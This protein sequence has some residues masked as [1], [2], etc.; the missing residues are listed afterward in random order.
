MNMTLREELLATEKAA[1]ALYQEKK[2]IKPDTNRLGYFQNLRT[3]ADL[4]DY[5]NKTMT[6]PSSRQREAF[7]IENGFRSCQQILEIH[8]DEISKA[9]KTTIRDIRIGD[10]LTTYEICSLSGSYDLMHGM[11]LNNDDPD[12]PFA[13]LRSEIGGMYADRV[14]S[15]PRYYNYSLEKESDAHY[16]KAQ[17]S[18]PVN[19]ALYSDFLR[20]DI[21]TQVK[22]LPAHLFVRHRQES[23]YLYQGVYFVNSLIDK[24]RTFELISSRFVAG[25]S[26]APKSDDR[27]LLRKFKD[28]RRSFFANFYAK[29]DGAIIGQRRLIETKDLNPKMFRSSP[30]PVTT[31]NYDDLTELLHDYLAD[32]ILF[33]RIGDI[34]EKFAFDF[35]VGRVKA[36]APQQVHNIK[37]VKDSNG[38]DLSSYE[39][40]GKTIR[41][42]QIEVKSTINKDPYNPFF[43]SSNE[44][45]TM[46]D[47]PQTYWLYRVF[48]INAVDPKLF[49]LRGGVKENIDHQPSEFA[50]SIRS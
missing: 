33:Q 15:D 43:M 44:F 50:C 4:A 49:P 41:P 14:A 28:D 40:V 1:S 7:K 36:F 9:K 45:R 22:Q 6:T 17:F 30:Q 35:E 23:R 18:K 12:H 37:K 2:G 20:Q 10:F 19:S 34:G 16:Q 24:N 21:L 27:E 3:N 13:I 25:I 31:M 11:S 5:I 29:D 8:E 26:S 38:F 32:Q 47:N 39:I 46:C 42:V 48:D